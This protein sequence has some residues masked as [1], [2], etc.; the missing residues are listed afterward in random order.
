MKEY[1]EK[2]SV[3]INLAIVCIRKGTKWIPL[4]RHDNDYA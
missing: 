3:K 2:A 1:F 4:C